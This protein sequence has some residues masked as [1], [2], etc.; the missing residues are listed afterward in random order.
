MDS[1]T[2]TSKS[3]NKYMPW[4]LVLY[5]LFSGL[6]C[7]ESFLYTFGNHLNEFVNQNLLILTRHAS[8]I[9]LQNR[10]LPT[11]LSKILS[12]SLN[13]S[14]GD[15]TLLT[16][17]YEFQLSALMITL[18]MWQTTKNNRATV[19]LGSL[20]TSLFMYLVN[21]GYWL[22]PAD[23]ASVIFMSAMISTYI[24]KK[25]DAIKAALYL[26]IFLAWQASF[27]E[28]IFVPIFLF[29]STNKKYIKSFDLKGIATNPA[30]SLL[31]LWGVASIILT[32]LVRHA[33]FQSE[34]I[35]LPTDVITLFGTWIV[36]IPDLKL[37]MT[38]IHAFLKVTNTLWVGFWWAQGSWM[39]LTILAMI[40]SCIDKE[41]INQENFFVLA[42]FSLLVASVLLIFPD[43]G[44]SNTFLLIIPCLAVLTALRIDGH[45]AIE[46]ESAETY[47]EPK[48]P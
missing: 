34:I 36:F 11:Y 16:F 29:I 5:A 41:S 38:E 3:S 19:I 6:A 18:L 40:F 14:F 48:H 42:I 28:A 37:L 13:I 21:S 10:L 31:V 25:T 17:R 30:S 33:L 12:T 39:L 4:W 22:Y 20:F 35:G 26:S 8:L 46:P 43:W 1:N 44:E 2:L 9:Q 15:A 32:K 45:K 7:Y 24:S 27:E 23:L 47:V